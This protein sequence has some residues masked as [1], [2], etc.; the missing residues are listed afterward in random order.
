MTPE[1]LSAK[2]F[3]SL[4]PTG[5]Q[6]Q[7][8][9][10]LQYL[11]DSKVPLERKALE[12]ERR[13]TEITGLA[14]KDTR[15]TIIVPIRNGGIY[16]APMLHTLASADVPRNAHATFLFVTNNC[17]DGALSKQAVNSLL[18]T[19]GHV[20]K[21][22]VNEDF[23]DIITDA[24]IQ[25]SYDRVII[26]NT[27]F[28]HLDTTTP[29]KANALN[30][31]NAI[32]A[33]RN[34]TAL[35][36]DANTFVEPD[37]VAYIFREAKNLSDQTTNNIKLIMGTQ[38]YDPLPKPQ[39]PEGLQEIPS[40]STLT[41]TELLP[42]LINKKESIPLRGSFMAWNPKDLQKNGGF[43]NVANEDGALV[44]RLRSKGQKVETTEK[45]IAWEIRPHTLEDR[46]R[47]LSR[48]VRGWLQTITTYP[49]FEQDIRDLIPNMKDKETGITYQDLLL[50]QKDHPN[51][52]VDALPY[53][54]EL[55]KTAYQ[56]GKKEFENHP[57]D[58][59]W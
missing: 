20:D 15:I 43:P 18:H 45:A 11:L 54:F 14:P 25:T 31:G 19:F 40:L 8:L 3:I 5:W 32:A 35:C 28:I 51:V 2:D 55:S 34:S 42:V 4:I 50:W 56:L 48:L 39:L 29:G 36:I 16:L 23:P 22:N 46:S 59:S 9:P 27:E 21:R 44:F 17:T 38:K 47:T 12:Q 30:L 24:G 52:S 37:A 57:N 1:Y 10:K 41:L 53:I 26:N 33:F 13:W 58:I 6:K 49:E 7:G